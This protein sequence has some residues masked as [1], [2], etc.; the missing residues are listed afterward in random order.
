MQSRYLSPY[1]AEKDGEGA[2]DA[3]LEPSRRARLAAGPSVRER[4]AVPQWVPN[5]GA[6]RLDQRHVLGAQPLDERRQGQ[7]LDRAGVEEPRSPGVEAD[8]VRSPVDLRQPDPR[9]GNPEP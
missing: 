3:G 9:D 2:M 7:W 1:S 5:R 6:L 8:F 4:E